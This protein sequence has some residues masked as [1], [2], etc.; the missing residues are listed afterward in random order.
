M[1]HHFKYLVH[2]CIF[3]MDVMSSYSIYVECRACNNCDLL[4]EKLTSLN[5]SLKY[6]G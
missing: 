1:L 3:K 4:S 5:N 2:L 6:T